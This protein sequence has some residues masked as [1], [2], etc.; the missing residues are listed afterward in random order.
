MPAP[1][2]HQTAR[3]GLLPRGHSHLSGLTTASSPL[4]RPVRKAPAINGR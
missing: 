2:A 4:R 1:C 3:R